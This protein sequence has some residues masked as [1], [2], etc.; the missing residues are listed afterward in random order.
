MKWILVCFVDPAAPILQ[1]L[2]KVA[3]EQ[4]HISLKE[5]Y[6]LFLPASSNGNS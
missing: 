3:H 2:E 1:D 5:G 6:H 4:P